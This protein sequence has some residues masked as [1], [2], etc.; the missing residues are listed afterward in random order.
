MCGRY[1]LRQTTED[2]LTRF[3]IQLVLFEML[4]RYNIAPSQT[5]AVVRA[6]GERRLEGL[7]WGL[8]PFWAKDLKKTK[9]M[10][11]ARMETLASKPSFKTC[12]TRRR[13]LVP[14]DGFFEWKTENDKRVPLHITMKDKRLF[15]FAGL[16]D[17]WKSADG[18]VL[19]TCTIITVPANG[20]ITEI[21]DRMPAILRREDEER[22]LDTAITSA[23]DI[24]HLL[25]PY[26][27]E[28]MEATTVSRA[29]NSPRTDSPE[30][31]TPAASGG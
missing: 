27:A 6:N 10:I 24:L 8:V 31:V 18:Q 21:H 17:T 14:S 15:A 1:T 22:W 7:K 12:L 26:P 25:G 29:V 30:C 4:P 23:A 9:P 5:V 20:W 3:G 11:N 28:E 19:E 13:C 2:L 16:W